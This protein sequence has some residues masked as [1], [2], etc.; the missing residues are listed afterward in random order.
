MW[1]WL[2]ALFGVRRD[3]TELPRPRNE[4]RPLRAA[5][6]PKAQPARRR[7][8]AA[9]AA[10]FLNGLVTP[11]EPVDLQTMGADDRV[12]LAG[13]LKRLRENRLEVPVLPQA[14]IEMSRLLANPNTDMAE[15]V[16]VLAADPS[17]S[18]EVLRV[19]NSAYYGSAQPTRSIRAAV[20]RVGLNQIR[21]LLVVSHLKSKVLQGGTFHREAVW[22]SDL[23]LSLAHL[24][25]FLA[26][27]LGFDP[28][29]A[30]TRGLL[31]HVEH[32]VI[33]GTVAEVSKEHKK[34]LEPTEG[35]LLQA[36]HRFGPKVRAVAA[37]AWS[38]EDFLGTEDD[39]AIFAPAYA[40]MRQAIVSRWV[41]A[42][43]EVE[44]PGVTRARLDQCLER[45]EAADEEGSETP[46]ASASPEPP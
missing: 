4:P 24:A 39:S 21:G 11:A 30:F 35:G 5:P 28:D 43:G 7:R 25:R 17:L 8:L 18:V 2:L 40:A 12:F 13:I 20:V 36:F 45:A 15:Y 3:E 27:D 44:V 19:A 34:K 6:Q 38:L 22:L 31:M 37:H 14:A 46:T 1:K 29:S 9:E 23:S 33:L 41:G 26:A 32:F 10:G 16:R 42:E